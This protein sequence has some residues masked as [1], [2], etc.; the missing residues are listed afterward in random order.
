MV[1]VEWCKKQQKGIKLIEPN[2][3]LSKEYIQTA[4]ETLDVLKI[5]DINIKLTQQRIME[6][7]EKMRRI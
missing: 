2:N 4:E 3:N 7:R 5:K 1:S 6:I